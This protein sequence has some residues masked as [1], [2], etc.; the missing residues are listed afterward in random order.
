LKLF[1]TE[2]RLSMHR[3]AQEPGAGADSTGGGGG[4]GLYKA[5]AASCVAA[6]R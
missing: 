2:I 1:A 6:K 4:G 5:P 3:I